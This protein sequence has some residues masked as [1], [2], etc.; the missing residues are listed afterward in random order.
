MVKDYNSQL[1]VFDIGLIIDYHDLEESAPQG[2][3]LSSNI[4]E[5]KSN[6]IL[7]CLGNLTGFDMLMTLIIL[8]P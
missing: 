7:K 2:C 5:F 8:K 1:K 4:L 3:V 6:D